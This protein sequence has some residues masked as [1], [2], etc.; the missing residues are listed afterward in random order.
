[1]KFEITTCYTRR[2]TRGH[3]QMLVGQGLD[4]LSK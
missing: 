3:L 1:M 4:I 2:L